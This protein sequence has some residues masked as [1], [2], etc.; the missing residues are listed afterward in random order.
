MG[1][2]LVHAANPAHAENRGARPDSAVD[3]R[4]QWEED[5]NS[6]PIPAENAP[7]PTENSVVVVRFPGGKRVCAT[8]GEFMIRTDQPRAKGGE[9]LAPD[10]YTLFL[11]SLATCSG[12]YVLAFCQARKIATDAVRLTQEA[13][14]DEEGK[15]ASV[16]IRIMLP[17]DFPAKYESAIAAAAAG[18]KVKKVLASPPLVTVETAKP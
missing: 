5:M 3:L 16:R 1:M 8:V 9:G 18:C 14:Y 15:L 2:H 10:P 12:A 17:K 7:L 4:L 11:A 13:S 6:M